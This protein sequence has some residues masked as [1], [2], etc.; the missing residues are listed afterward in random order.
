MQTNNISGRSYEIQ[1][2]DSSTE[3]TKRLVKKH[4]HAQHKHTTRKEKIESQVNSMLDQISTC[5][6]RK[7]RENESTEKNSSAK[8]SNTESKACCQ[9]ANN[10]TNITDSS[11]SEQDSMLNSITNSRET[12]FTDNSAIVSSDST[13]TAPS[14]TDSTSTASI[15]TTKGR[16]SLETMLSADGSGNV[17]EEQL[18]SA[19]VQSLLE[20]KNKDLGKSYLQE[21]SNS[22]GKGNQFEDS[23]KEALK[24]LVKQG[25]ITKAEAEKI[26]GNSFRAAQL[27]SNLDALYDSKGGKG[28]D[29]VAVMKLEDAIK[30]AKQILDD[31]KSNKITSATRSL[32]A[33]SNKKTNS[34]SSVSSTGGAKGSSASG[35]GFL[36]K[37]V[38]D[39]NGKLVVLFPPNLSGDI[40]SAGIYS[41]LPASYEN[42]IEEGKFSGDGNGNRSHF[43][44][45]K[46][47]SSYPDGVFAVAQLKDGSQAT[48]KVE[49]SASRNT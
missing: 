37:P 33:P 1:K 8:S 5:I 49:D 47:G 30:S 18:Q 41:K 16:S 26:N 13:T 44:F 48:F 12:G 42:L 27:D 40:I 4:S 39:S 21:L 29:T 7:L 32:D 22:I 46:P 19:I 23:V 9:L 10:P 14:N 43:R 45:S 20:Q 28:D 36:W 34:S 25:A 2:N 35:N 17:N 6:S 3:N 31:I 11:A 24:A 15:S 38:S